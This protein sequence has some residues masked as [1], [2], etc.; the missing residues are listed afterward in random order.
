MITISHTCSNCGSENIVRNGNNKS[1]S[2]TYHCKDCK[3]Y[4]VLKK[5]K[6]VDTEA[7]ARTYE[8]RNSYRSTGRIFNIS[9]VSVYNYLKKKQ[10]R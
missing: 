2:P 4:R 1:G 10:K 7:L 9:H 3:V 6:E 5:K 8:E